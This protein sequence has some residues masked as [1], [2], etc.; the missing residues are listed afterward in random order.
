MGAKLVAIFFTATTVAAAQ[1]VTASAS[2]N[3][4]TFNYQIGAALPPAQT[5]SV[6]A[7]S[8]TP[9]YTL[10]VSPATAL[11]LT[12]TPDN[13]KLP[14][15]LSVRVNPT[16]MAVGQYAASVNITVTGIA[17][18]VSVAVTLNVTAP[19]PTLTLS[20]NSA[21]FVTSPAPALTAIISLSTSGNP[22]SFA[23]SVTG[24]SWLTVSPTTG[25]VL[26]GSE[27][28]LLLTADAT[29]LAPSA[30]AYTGKITITAYGVP[31][32]NKTQTITANLTVN[33]ATPTIS[34]IWPNSV[35]ANTGAATITVRGS[36]FYTATA[37][38]AGSTPLTTTILG[39]NVLQAIIPATMLTAAGPLN[40]IVSN[41]APGGDSAPAVFTVSNAPVIQ[42]IVN[43]ASYG[44]NGS[45][46]PGEIVALFGLGI[47][48][49]SPVSMSTATK[50]GYLDTA[51]GGLSVTI[52]SQPAPLL[53]A[54]AN[55]ITVQ[56]P[57]EATVGS[58]KAVV[59]T[60]GTATPSNTTVTIVQ[61]VPGI[62]TADA[63]G[64]GTAAAV[65]LPSGGGA[66]GL[67]SASFPA[68]AG[69]LVE[70]YVTGEGDYLA[71]PAQHTGYII[72][73]TLTPLP[74][75]APLPSVT[76]GTAPANVVY[77][78]PL[79]GSVIGLLQMNVIVPAGLTAGNAPVVVTINGVQTQS[80]VTLAVK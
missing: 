69:D 48:P 10:A 60:N 42:A 50:P 67:N 25:V 9:S 79:Y 53:Y 11:W 58:N 29:G 71:A 70:L 64:I 14:A 77:A 74:Q 41:P 46:S 16:G 59:V 24:A 28:P 61:N 6:R 80:N 15:S 31:T 35:Q 44:S 36:N 27:F 72:P 37:A 65:V 3:T 43:A 22:V 12:A 55:Q 78:G 30:K 63:S 19:L 8:G 51:I 49:A 73:A 47:G 1:T 7:S 54:D 18:V 34:S 57:Y 62:F 33:A 23:A 5:V 38:K 13:G 4:L 66:A 26:P 45:V 68:H 17:A 75:V 21:T 40:I 39:P 32:A 52:D 20:T 56:V 76:I 2:P